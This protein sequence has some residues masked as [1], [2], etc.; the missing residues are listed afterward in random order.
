M[1]TIDLF[2]GGARGWSVAA[3]DLGLEPAIGIELDPV[4]CRT[5]AAAGPS[6]RLRRRGDLP[7]R[8]VRPCV[9]HLRVTAVPGLLEGGAPQRSRRQDGL[10]GWYQMPVFTTLNGKVGM[11]K[12]NCTT[13][14]KIAPVR[15]LVRR[16]WKE[17]GR[18]QVLQAD[19]VSLDEYHRAS[20]TGVKYITAW[21]PLLDDPD[22]QPHV[23]MSRGDCEAWMEEHGYPIPVK[24]GCTCCP[25]QDDQSWAE[26][27]D[28][29]PD[30]FAEVVALDES[31]RAGT[32]AQQA[33]FAAP[34][35]LHRSGRPLG[36]VPLPTPRPRGS[37]SLAMT[38]GYACRGGCGL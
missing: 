2:A 24:S 12:R 4:A 20:P 11:A 30:T 17:A 32:R 29:E 5:A 38:L 19:G 16:L 36:E 31:M 10:L 25:F 3:A 15:R 9:R 18:P 34:V 33:G 21:H 27:R 8:P 26:L 35:Y 23:P 6:D 28:E 13:D 14:F 37:R 1:T 22:G 7:A